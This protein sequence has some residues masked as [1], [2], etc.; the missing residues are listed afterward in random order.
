MQTILLI[1]LL[2]A[3]I[4]IIVDDFRH[5]TVSLLWLLA[6]LVIS[7]L[8][9][10]TSSM[11]GLDIA[12]NAFINFG[13]LILNYWLIT[14][15]FSIRKKR[16]LN[17]TNGYLGSGDIV[18]LL[19]ISTLFS[20]FNFVCF[21]LASF[22]FALLSWI[23]LQRKNKTIPLAGLQAVFLSVQILI[24]ILKY[25]KWNANDDQHTLNL[26]MNFIGNE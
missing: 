12:K 5:R 21:L 25:N 10:F 17:L 6:L 18:F 15:Y 4:P 14:L 22:L 24:T 11:A 7:L 8:I 20:P 1:A 16:L 13:I 3:L 23:I 9:Q 26:V 19:A 2:L